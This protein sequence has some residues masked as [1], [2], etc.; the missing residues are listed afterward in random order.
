MR[1]KLILITLTVVIPFTVFSQCKNVAKK[2]CLPKLSPYTHNGQVNSSTLLAGQTAEL[3][4]TFNSGLD[5]RILVCA[6]AVLGKASFKLIDVEKNVVFDSKESN[7][8]ELWDFN[9]ESTQQFTL[10]VTVPKS[11][12]PNNIVPSGCVSVLVGFKQ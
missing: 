5:Y 1:F 4:M 8:P 9:V 6:S 10:E 7:S 12:S 11:N 2:E 3:Q